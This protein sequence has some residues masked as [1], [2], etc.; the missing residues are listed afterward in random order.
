MKTRFYITETYCCGN[1]GTGY[2]VDT[3]AEALAILEKIK[4]FDEPHAFVKIEEQRIKWYQRYWRPVRVV[5][6]WWN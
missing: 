1:L 3:E 4:S 2:A 6:E 5:A